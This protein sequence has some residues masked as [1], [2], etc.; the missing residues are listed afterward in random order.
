MLPTSR[1]PGEHAYDCT[2]HEPCCQTRTASTMEL[3]PGILLLEPLPEKTGS[4]TD[5]GHAI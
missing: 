2:V 1:R 5:N 3:T 4:L